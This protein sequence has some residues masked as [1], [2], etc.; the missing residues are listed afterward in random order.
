MRD[1]VFAFLKIAVKRIT[2]L[3][4]EKGL[5]Y[6]KGKFKAVI[7]P[8]QYWYVPFITIIQKFDVRS[9][10]VSITRQEVLSSDSVTIKVSLA[11]NY[12]ITDP[13]V[14]VN[15][16]QSFQDALYLELRLALREIIGSAEI[17]SALNS[18]N[19]L[20]KKRI[21]LTERRVK[22]F[23]LRL[24]RHHVPRKAEGDIHS[25]G[26]CQKGGAGGS[27]KG[28]RRDRGPSQS[29]QCR[30][31]ARRQ[32]TLDAASVRPSPR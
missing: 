30:K 16:V 5:H 15:K 14:E 28:S 25:G 19:E 18:R 2:I 4:Y 27:R 17:D 12:E 26:Q 29:G 1:A 31:D 20:S 7:E 9:R 13:H 24:E 6:E 21:D 3:E 11:A 10:F 23:G 8:E 22:D 32:P